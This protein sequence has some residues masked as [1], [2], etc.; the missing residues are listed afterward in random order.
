M[1]SGRP[2]LNRRLI[3]VREHSLYFGM[4]EVSK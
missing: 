2:A 3:A 4:T 1:V